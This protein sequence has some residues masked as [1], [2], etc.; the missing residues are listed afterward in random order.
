MPLRTLALVA[1]LLAAPGCGGPSN[2]ADAAAADLSGPEPTPDLGSPDLTASD[3][4]APP[5]GDLAEPDLAPPVMVMLSPGMALLNPGQ[6]QLFA[7]KVTGSANQDV[8]F[9]IKQGSFGGTITSDG[10][11]VAPAAYGTYDVIAT[12]MADPTKSAS[13]SVTVTMDPQVSVTISPSPVTL[14]PLQAQTFTAM[15][16]GDPNNAVT[17]TASGGTIDQNGN[18]TAPPL[19]GV[20]RV[21]ATSKL[22]STKSD[23][24]LVTVPVA[25]VSGMVTYTGS[26]TGRIYLTVTQDCCGSSEASAGT[27]IAAPGAYSIRN[28]PQGQ[29]TITAWRD[30]LGVGMRSASDPMGALKVTVTGAATAV[31]GANIALV[32]STPPAPQPPQPQ[33]ACGGSDAAVLVWK[34]S[35]D[36]SGAE[37]ADHYKVYCSTSSAPDATNSTIRTV[38]SGTNGAVVQPLA[39]GTWYCTVAGVANGQEGAKA[40]VSPGVVIG[41]PA[42]GGPSVAGTVSFGAAATGSL[43]ALAYSP[44]VNACTIARVASPASPQAYTVPVPAAGP[45]GV[46]AF[47]DQGDDGYLGPSEQSSSFVLATVT[48][49]ASPAPEI[50]LP[51]GPVTF[52]ITTGHLA[53]YGSN[54]QYEVRLPVISAEKQPVAATLISAVNVQVPF[55]V[56]LQGQHD[57]IGGEII[58]GARARIGSLVPAAGDAY[59]FDVTL[60]DGSSLRIG[61]TVPSAPLALP[62]ALAPSGPGVSTKPNIA[63]QAP[64]PA[65][66]SAYTYQVG[67]SPDS[68]GNEVF[69]ADQLPSSTTSLPW[70][71]TALSPGTIYRLRVSVHDSA[72][73]ES[74]QETQFTTQ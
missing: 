23:T 15:V 56:G 25:T 27:S 14:N 28:V 68:G 60:A 72:G 47:L 4:L 70:S 1:A 57:G 6:K 48:G 65:P 54:V 19:G 22:D 55:D 18:Y 13:S 37:P 49:P 34:G 53:Y 38:L 2:A 17:W 12:S 71:G 40:T 61:A 11:Y 7:A 64:N 3:L 36:A 46:L 33:V 10:L 21:T 29:L 30:K 58:L 74:L 35:P 26:A 32:D 63:W 62:S 5:P 39:A 8:F 73:N 51:R 41:P 24:A 43:Y 9:S 42:P 16:N 67:V 52:A 59:L 31:G 44:V 66:A 50:A 20:Y 69:R 45:Y